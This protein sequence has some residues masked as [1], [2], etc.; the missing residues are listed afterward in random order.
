[1]FNVSLEEHTYVQLNRLPVIKIIKI[2]A[3]L[4]TN[5]VGSLDEVLAIKLFAYNVLVT[6]RGDGV[7]SVD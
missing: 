5:T 7:F 6:D 1:M 4:V 2:T 3:R